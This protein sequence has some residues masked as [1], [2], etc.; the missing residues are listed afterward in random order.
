[1]GVHVAQTPRRISAATPSRPKQPS[2]GT[3]EREGLV[4]A[5]THDGSEGQGKGQAE[6][7]TMKRRANEC[8]THSGIV[9][10]SLGTRQ[11]IPPGL[12][13]RLRGGSTAGT[14]RRRRSIRSSGGDVAPLH[15]VVSGLRHRGKEGGGGGGRGCWE[16]GGGG[17]IL[18]AARR[19]RPLGR[20]IRI[21]MSFLG[22]LS[23]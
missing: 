23:C 20:P 21:W 10:D 19:E 2:P 22:S 3:R 12:P 1:M 14:N 15:R 17:R 16:S 18:P 7:G 11:R 5:H 4:G 6:R 8:R 9:Q 13:A